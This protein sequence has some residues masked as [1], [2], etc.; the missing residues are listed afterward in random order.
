VEINSTFE[1]HFSF[2]QEDVNNFSN[3]TGDLNPIHLDEEIAKNSI[4]KKRIV[5]GF[6]SAS[7]F[8][9]VFGTLWPGHGTIYLSQSLNFTK[10]MYTNE[11]YSAKFEVIEVLPKNK[12]WVQTTIVDS[13][14]ENTIEG[15]ALL[16]LVSTTSV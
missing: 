6:L 5:H 3:V 12:I 8:S 13:N 15:K 1:Y 10:P 2:T 16:K 9:K 7:I 14:N 11:R 4:F